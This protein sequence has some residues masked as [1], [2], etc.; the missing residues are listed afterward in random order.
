MENATKALIMAGAILISIL[1]ISVGLILFN[2]TSGM[3]DQAAS[4]SDYMSISIF[5]SRFTQHFGTNIS[6]S[7]AKA[8]VNSIIINN[9][10]SSNPKLL[11]NLCDKNGTHIINGHS[12]T[13]QELQ[14]LS[15]HISV[16]SKYN[17][18]A[19]TN[20][21]EAGS[22]GGY[23]NGYLRCISIKLAN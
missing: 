23:R 8:F 15:N 14:T 12:S 18:Y 3:V 20:C 16:T 11:V 5:N 2:S 7:Q 21:G 13:V 1:L 6:G 22:T 9:S 17:I 19:T 10:Y 4:S